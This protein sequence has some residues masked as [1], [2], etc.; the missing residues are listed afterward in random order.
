MGGQSA[1]VTR[2]REWM[3]VGRDGRGG[4]NTQR[5]LDCFP[6]MADIGRLCCPCSSIHLEALRRI[7]EGTVNI[8]FA[9][10]AVAPGHLH[11]RGAAPHRKPEC[12]PLAALSR[13]AICHVLRGGHM[14]RRGREPNQ[15]HKS[16]H[17]QA[18]EKSRVIAQLRHRRTGSV[19]SDKDSGST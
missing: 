17:Y 19:L 10:S 5:K 3:A 7:W 6:R 15:L 9:G 8:H 1:C 12:L 2:G 14:T 13:D 16:V 11:Q 4:K 18:R